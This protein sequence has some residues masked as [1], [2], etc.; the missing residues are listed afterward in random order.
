ML[1]NSDT[2]LLL[3]MSLALSGLLLPRRA[4]YRVAVVWPGATGIPTP[5]VPWNAH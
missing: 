1:F 5:Q 2:F 3:F 4:S